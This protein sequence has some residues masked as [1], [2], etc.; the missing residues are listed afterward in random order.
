MKQTDVKLGKQEE[1]EEL[2]VQ[3]GQ[4][5]QVFQFGEQNES[6]LIDKYIS[7]FQTSKETQ[8]LSSFA[9]STAQAHDKTRSK[10]PLVKQNNLL[11]QAGRNKSSA[12]IGSQ[13]RTREARIS[14]ANSSFEKIDDLNLMSDNPKETQVQ[15]TKKSPT[16]SQKTSTNKDKTSESH[17]TMEEESNPVLASY[18]QPTKVSLVAV[19]QN[20]EA[21]ANKGIHERGSSDVFSTS[22]RKRTSTRPLTASGAK[23]L[24]QQVFSSKRRSQKEP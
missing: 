22:P 12:G 10:S 8:I 18:M 6:R 15:P 23:N 1:A 20:R 17:K 16:C 7:E 2:I 24:S 11:N 21:R 14:K 4:L 5:T 3:V 9:K 13:R 19:R